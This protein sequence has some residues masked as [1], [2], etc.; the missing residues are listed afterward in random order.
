METQYL[1]I[2]RN[3]LENGQ[4]RQTRNGQ[5][6]SLFGSSLE[7]DLRDGFPLLTTMRQGSL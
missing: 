6:L 3:V 2:V 4:R 5:V 1:D 7:C